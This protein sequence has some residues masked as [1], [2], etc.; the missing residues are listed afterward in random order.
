LT[1][2]AD[3]VV[4][5]N[6]RL[7]KEVRDLR[8]RVAAF[9]SSRWWR[10]HPRLLLGRLRTT[11]PAAATP[12]TR[13][14]TAQQS[15]V[16]ARFRDE[17]V[18]QGRFSEDWFTVHIP[19]WEEVLRGLEGKRAKLL[20]LGSFEGLSAAFLL[21]RLPDA[22]ITCV[23][24]FAGL[25]SYEAYGIATELEDAFDH[26]VALVDGTRV[27]KI[28]GKTQHVLPTLVDEEQ[29]FDLIYVDAS[30][31]ALDVLVDV[32]LAWQLLLPSGV[33]IFD[34]YGPIPDGE[35]P[36]AHPTPA[37]DAFL[38]LVRGRYEI[39]DQHRQLIVRKTA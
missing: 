29:A 9:E 6:Q 15:E 28:V 39:V 7:R 25:S 17:V 32:V 20:E 1:D 27:R 18:T 26:N 21:W 38:Q 22:H 34:D 16:A 19:I 14:A 35:D 10:L 23:D 4:G 3:N 24:T 37:I 36:L 31:T 12:A 11:R 13:P 8:A 5:E 30:H 33:A 2:T